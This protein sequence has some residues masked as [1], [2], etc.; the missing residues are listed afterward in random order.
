[1]L[2][3]KGN[4]VWKEG[5]AL[6]VLPAVTDEHFELL[7]LMLMYVLFSICVWADVVDLTR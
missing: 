3:N 7:C 5:L 4:K 6:A 1:M 2:G